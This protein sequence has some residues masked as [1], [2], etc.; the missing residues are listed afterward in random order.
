MGAGILRSH[1]SEQHEHGERQSDRLQLWVGCCSAA[2]SIVLILSITDI[3]IFVVVVVVVVV[4]VLVVVVAWSS[5]LI[6]FLTP[7]LMLIQVLG[8]IHRDRELFVC[9]KDGMASSL[10]EAAFNARFL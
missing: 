4:V 6:S 8:R 7:R 2:V 5:M 10:V 3:L 9:F 1:S